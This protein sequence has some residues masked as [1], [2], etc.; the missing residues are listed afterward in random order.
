ML[1][2]AAFVLNT[3]ALTSNLSLLDIDFKR[4]SADNIETLAVAAFVVVKFLVPN[5]LQQS[6]L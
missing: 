3:Y 1:A 4:Q 2:L 6:F 5:L